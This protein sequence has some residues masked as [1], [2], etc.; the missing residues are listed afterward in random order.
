[1]AKTTNIQANAKTTV[2]INGNFFSESYTEEWEIEEGDDVE[3]CRAMLWATVHGEVDKQ[4][5]EDIATFNQS[6]PAI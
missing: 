1:M 5:E 4:I 6:S 3:A 2:N